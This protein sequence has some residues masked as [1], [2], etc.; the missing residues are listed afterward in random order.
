MLKNL[1][2]VGLL[3]L[4]IVGCNSA[5]KD[6]FELHLLSAPP[7]DNNPETKSVYI[8][9]IINKANS[10][11]TIAQVVVKP[12]FSDDTRCKENKQIVNKKI[13]KDQKLSIA[14]PCDAG[15]NQVDITTSNG[16][17][18]YVGD[19]FSFEVNKF[20]IEK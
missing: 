19:L 16:V 7:M 3:A 4:L 13:E 18:S 6:N 9:E 10:A 20:Y 1:S 5:N 8:L 17:S 2:L 11:T 15:Q 14:I 12:R